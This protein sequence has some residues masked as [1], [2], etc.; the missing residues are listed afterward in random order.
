MSKVIKQMEMNDLRRTFDGVRDLVVLTTSKL[1][2][3]GE[4]T[5]RAALRKKGVRLKVVK[6]SLARRVFKEMNLSIPDDSPY[7]QKQTM[8]AWGANSIAELS[9]EVDA[10]LKNPKAA[11]LYKGK[12]GERITIKGAVADGAPITFDVAKA[13]PTREDLLAQ[14]AGMIIGP[15]SAIAGCL[16]GPGAMLASQLK[17]IAEKAGEA[18]PA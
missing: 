11:G 18:T 10:E 16:D 17:S 15:G 9:K 14:I 5:F 1:S 2:A 12:D 3:Q 4:Y 13:M 8:L 7:W 6:N